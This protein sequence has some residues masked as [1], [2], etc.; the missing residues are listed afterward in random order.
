MTQRTLHFTLGPVQGFIGEARR[1]R[2]FWAGSFLLSVLSGHAMVALVREAERVGLSADKV[3]VFPETQTDALFEAIKNGKNAPY[4]GTLPNR[5]KANVTGIERPGEL[6]A[7]A[8]SG[9][10]K[11]ICDAVWSD[12]VACSAPKSAQGGSAA[13]RIWDRQTNGFWNIAWVVGDTPQD[14]SD[15]RW[16]DLRKNWR[17]QYAGQN[18]AEGGDLCRMMGRFQEISGFSRIHERQLQSEFWDDMRRAQNRSLDLRADERLCAIALVKRMFPVV[19]AKRSGIAKAIPFVP[20]GAGFSTRYWP[21]TSYVAALP[22]LK[23]LAL[24][25]TCPGAGLA[26]LANEVFAEG[27]FGEATSSLLYGL[28]PD[29]FWK[30]DGHFFHLDGISALVRE[31]IENDTLAPDLRQTTVQKLSDELRKTSG[32]LAANATRYPSEFYAVLRMDGDG[33]GRRLGKNEKRIKSSLALFASKVTELLAPGNPL[34]GLLVYAGGDDVLAVFPV[35]TALE[36]A[37]QVRSAFRASFLEA[38]DSGAD[39]TISASIV[40]AHFKHPI[41]AVLKESI[42]QLDDVAKEKNGRNSIAISVL[43]PGG[44]AAQ[45]VSA[46]DGRND[47]VSALERLSAA[48]TGEAD[49]AIAG[50]LVHKLREKYQSLFVDLEGRP[51]EFCDP[52]DMLPILVRQ[53]LID[54]FGGN[55]KLPELRLSQLSDQIV[56]VLRPPHVTTS[57]DGS[58]GAGVA[59]GGGL[60]SRFISKESRKDIW[61]GS[62]LTEDHLDSQT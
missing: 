62:S 11:A 54:Q 48:Q 45:W 14:G 4:V 38:D 60:I 1:L 43:K 16:L 18:E 15:G 53:E 20:G 50:G 28:P 8:V 23:A 47:S 35:D 51:S 2:D 61:S 32:A 40:Y 5:F 3:I 30:L 44:V 36:A 46:F 56:N 59:F 17:S 55:R 7:E 10:W 49:R 6:C 57:Q 37:L 13:K 25:D 34:L 27:N 19:V 31:R 42:H 41:S 33:I 58:S 29:P 24:K 52:D 21:S 39:F 26:S 22:W 12:V 9:A